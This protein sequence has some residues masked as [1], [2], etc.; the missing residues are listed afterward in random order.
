MKIELVVNPS[1]MRT[2][3]SR[4]ISNSEIKYPDIRVLVGKIP[5]P[6]NYYDDFPDS[7][8]PVTKAFMYLDPDSNAHV[9]P[10]ILD[11]IRLGKF[12]TQEGELNSPANELTQS[13]G[14]KKI[15]ILIVIVS[16]PG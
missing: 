6:F 2:L 5:T 14:L 12:I 16:L 15:D 10:K 7:R 9:S 13:V 4:G 3:H 11:P 1:C 8:L